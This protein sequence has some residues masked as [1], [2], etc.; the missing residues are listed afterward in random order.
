MGPF[1]FQSTHVNI[2]NK[3]R[4][5]AG[6]ERVVTRVVEQSKSP[7]SFGVIPVIP[8][9]PDPLVDLDSILLWNMMEDGTINTRE[10]LESVHSFRR[11]DLQKKP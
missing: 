10:L 5:R 7:T 2:K 11:S 4:G 6:F 1:P 9:I 3:K 8:V